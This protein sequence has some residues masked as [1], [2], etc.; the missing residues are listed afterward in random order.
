MRRIVVVDD[1]ASIGAAVRDLLAARANKLTDSRHKIQ[2]A[3]SN[4]T[5]RALARRLSLQA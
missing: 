4:H 3:N 1:D 2:I 5:H